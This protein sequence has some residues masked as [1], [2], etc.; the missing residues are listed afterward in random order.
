MKILWTEP[1]IKDL[2]N[3]H[4]YIARDSE[5]YA[6]N[7]V[8]RIILAV[9]KLIDYRGLAES[10]LRL[11]RKRFGNFF[12]TTIASSIESNTSESKF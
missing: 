10:Y 6:S 9:D 12:I 8:Q 7:F 11:T 2:R 1:A 3:L 4:A 5:I